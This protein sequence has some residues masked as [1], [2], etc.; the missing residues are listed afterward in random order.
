MTDVRN[1]A[2]VLHQDMLSFI[3]FNVAIF[4][5][6]FTVHFMYGFYSGKMVILIKKP[7]VRVFPGNEHCLFKVVSQLYEIEVPSTTVPSTSSEFLR[8]SDQLL[9]AFQY[10]KESDVSG[11]YVFCLTGAE[12]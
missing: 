4:Y 6:Y 7:A 11:L 12:A 9:K 2:F 1:R 3:A 5:F 8:I 10:P